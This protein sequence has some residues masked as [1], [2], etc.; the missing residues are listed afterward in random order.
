LLHVFVPLSLFLWGFLPGWCLGWVS[1][2]LFCAFVLTIP[3]FYFSFLLTSG[4]VAISFSLK[5]AEV[6]HGIG[7]H[8]AFAGDIAHV[9]NLIHTPPFWIGGQLS[10]TYR[11]FSRFLSLSFYRLPSGRLFP[12][13]LQPS[14]VFFI[15]SCFYFLFAYPYH[16]S[17]YKRSRPFVLWRWAA[18][19]AQCIFASHQ[20]SYFR[21]AHPTSASI[22][23]LP[24]PP[25]HHT[26]QIERKNHKAS[27]DLSPLRSLSL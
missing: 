13:I 26:Y 19:A 8:I 1:T 25:P 20:R 15:H 23:S 12:S 24:V 4:R 10:L 5:T 6:V 2:D 16:C 22:G 18:S 9:T 11:V 3:S 21:S 17:L 14:Y 7:L 27:L